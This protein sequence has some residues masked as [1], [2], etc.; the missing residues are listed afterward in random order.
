MRL[1]I[2]REQIDVMA[3]VSEVN[4][5][6]AIAR[7][8]RSNYGDSIV[9][10]PEGGEFAV[11]DLQ[12]E[13]LERLVRVGIEKARRFQL[14]RQSSIAGFV[15]MM[16]SSAPNFEANR[17]CE[18]LLSDEE[19]TPDERSDEIPNVLSEKNWDAIRN[20]YDPQ[21]WILPEVPKPETGTADDRGADESEKAPDPM[22][23]T[24]TGKTLARLA[25]KPKETVDVQPQVPVGE[26]D[27]DVNTVKIDREK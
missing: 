18:V 11:T 27:M 6:R 8:L 22:A 23:K 1:N 5:E 15:A 25:K 13:T 7:D 2:R 19:K 3:A 4:F 24:V 20:E 12:E 16:F 21:A 10:L 17:L 26:L 14:T 9:R